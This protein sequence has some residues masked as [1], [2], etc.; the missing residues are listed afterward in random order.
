MTV[1][2]PA[3]LARSSRSISCSQ[4]RCTASLC[5]LWISALLRHVRAVSVTIRLRLLNS[6][7]RD[8]HRQ[9]R[10]LTSLCIFAAGVVRLQPGCREPTVSKTPRALTLQSDRHVL[11]HYIWPHRMVPDESQVDSEVV[12]TVVV[13]AELCTIGTVVVEKQYYHTM[14]S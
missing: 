11:S 12:T 13:V 2:V 6:N 3:R 9:A 7:G 1:V 10:L 14:I 4:Y 5:I 8:I